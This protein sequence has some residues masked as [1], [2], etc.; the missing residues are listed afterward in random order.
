M[1]LPV[2]VFVLVTGLVLG[3]YYLTTARLVPMLAGRRVGQRLREVG[4]IDIR[5]SS[6]LVMEEQSGP[7]PALDRVVGRTSSGVRLTR[8]IEQSG[9]RTTPSAMIL[10]SL[11]C[12]AVA[13]M[14][15]M[16]FGRL[17]MV[18]PIAAAIGMM[19]PLAWLS[20][21]RSARLKK[22]EEQFPEALDLLSRAI[23]AGHAFQTSMGMVADELAAPVGIEFRKTFERQNFGLPLRDAMNE[24]SERVPLLDVRFFV[25]AVAIQRETGGNLAEILDNL[26]HVVR[27]RFKIRRQVRVHTAHGRFTGWVLLILPAALA[28]ALSF[29][30]PDHTKTLFE[31]RLGQTMIAGAIVMQTAGYIW[32]RQ[33]IKIEV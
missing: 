33:I 13:A 5:S 2:L 14:L 29:I 7:L 26:A 9:V 16:L 11:G 31:S 24:L 3:G 32:I 18:A 10:A 1:A 12:A 21:K 4:Q 22:F 28:V 6:S 8:L 25:T 17:P 23:R 19:L 27:E 20:H 30:S 15:W